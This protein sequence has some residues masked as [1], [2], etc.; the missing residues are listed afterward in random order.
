LV[1]F[2]ERKNFEISAVRAPDPEKMAENGEICRLRETVSV[3]DSMYTKNKAGAEEGDAPVLKMVFDRCAE[4]TISDEQIRRVLEPIRHR[5]YSGQYNA[6]RPKP[7]LRLAA[8][9]PVAAAIII[10]LAALVLDA[11]FG[12]R[13]MEIP[14]PVI[15]LARIDNSTVTMTGCVTVNGSGAGGVCLTLTGIDDA[16]ISQT[17]VTLDDGTYDFCDLADGAYRLTAGALAGPGAEKSVYAGTFEVSGGKVRLIENGD[18]EIVVQG[19]QICL[20]LE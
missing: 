12:H 20:A 15:P 6:A 3:V 10:V 7:P 9:R 16:D 18:A 13:R 2:S 14:G 4:E 8:L 1:I 5:V 19:R 11:R 17:A